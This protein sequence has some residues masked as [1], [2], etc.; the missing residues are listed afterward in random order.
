MY[1]HE[2]GGKGGRITGTAGVS[3]GQTLYINVAGAGSNSNY[4]TTYIEQPA[5]G[6]FAGGGSGGYFYGGGGGGYSSISTS[7]NLANALFVA[8]GGGG[9]G[10]ATGVGD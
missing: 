10:S 5:A 7:A 8:G 4:G 2:V 9:T 3:A 6:G 1:Y